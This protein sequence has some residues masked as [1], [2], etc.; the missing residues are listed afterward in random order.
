MADVHSAGRKPQM[1]KDPVTG[2]MKV[3]MVP[4]KQDVKSEKTLTPA[5]KSGRERIAKKLPMKDFKKRYGDDAM[6]VKMATATNIAKKKYEGESETAG[7]EETKGA[8]KGY[9]FTRSGKL[10][11]GDADVDGPG[12]KKLRADPLDKQ[13]SKI[14]PLPEK[15]ASA[16]QQAAVMAKLKK[17]GK[18]K[19]ESVEEAV[20]Y[21]G[22]PNKDDDA[23][24]AARRRALA[25]QDNLLR[26]RK[27]EKE[28]PVEE[29][30]G[31]PQTA[32]HRRAQ[33]GSRYSD[34]QKKV[35][36]KGFGPDA[37]KGN[38]GNPSARAALKVKESNE[39]VEENYNWKVSHAGKDVHVKAPHAG[40]AVKKA[41]KGFG[42]MDLTKAKITNL[43]KVGTPA[44]EVFAGDY[45]MPGKMKKEE[46][47]ENY[48]YQPGKR[49]I[50]KASDEPDYGP[51]YRKPRPSISARSLNKKLYGKAMGSTMKGEA[52]DKPPFDPDPKTDGP[53]KDEYGNVVKKK[54]IAHFLAKKAMKKAMG[55]DK[56]QEGMLDRLADEPTRARRAKAA[57]DKGMPRHI[58]MGKYMVSS[59]DIEK[60]TKN[61][62]KVAETSDELKSRYVDKAKSDYKHQKF[63][64][65]I[66]KDMDAKDAEKHHRRKAQNRLTGIGRATATM[67]ESTDAYGKSMDAMA[68]KRKMDA[69]SSTDKDKLGK[70][71]AMMAKEKKPKNKP[72]EEANDNWERN[73]KRRIAMTVSGGKKVK[74]YMKTKVDQSKAAHAKQDPGAVKGGLGP[75]VVDR[76][77]A[78]KKAKEKGLRPGQIVMTRSSKQRKLPEETQLDEM[79]ANAA[80]TK[81][82]KDIKAYAAKDGGIDKKDMMNFAA[83]LELMGRAPNILQAGRIL[84][85]INK[86]FK[87]YDTDV[88]DRLSMYLKKHGLME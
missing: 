7:V 22:N 4:S 37:A 73:F 55:E 72:V 5:E 77:K 61:E 59:K 9:H 84:D 87:G 28:K 80:Y 81:A 64:A 43:G 49:V 16:A 70:L 45:K 88:R 30:V 36:L 31:A 69:I 56:Q 27:A 24:N 8:P 39:S 6:A 66:A 86:R 42:N 48:S 25:R 17:D 11:K 12:G 50:G 40:A 54:N 46:V 13:R 75:A 85:R 26:K 23:R 78:Y 71:A 34:L 58:A 38:M 53:R 18:Y 74:D 44:K 29:N 68:R 15:F 14:P 20:T 62:A 82:A 51:R 76:Q 1:Y 79:K 65:D 33:S 10:R 60:H 2:K 19:G 21:H 3:R 32:A 83:D 57:I 67:G 35:K 41:Q 52:K 47:E 63:S